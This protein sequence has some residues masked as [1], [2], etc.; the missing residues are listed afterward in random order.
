MFSPYP[1]TSLFSLQVDPKALL[2]CSFLHLSLLWITRL[3]PS[4]DMQCIPRYS[5]DLRAGTG[6]SSSFKSKDAYWIPDESEGF[7]MAEVS[8]CSIVMHPFM[9]A[10]AHIGRSINLWCWGLAV[11]LH[12]WVRLPGILLLFIT[13]GRHGRCSFICQRQKNLTS[14]PWEVALK[15]SMI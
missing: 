10:L 5:V 15:W 7:I 8:L 11:Y 14:V 4:T 2:L 9:W 13:L 6:Y 12:R 1:T 3:S